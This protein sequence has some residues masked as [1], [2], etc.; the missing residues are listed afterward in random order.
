MLLDRVQTAGRDHDG[1][2][3]PEVTWGSCR[4]DESPESKDCS[5]VLGEQRPPE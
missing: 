4:E 3:Q 5:Q 1:T 2:G